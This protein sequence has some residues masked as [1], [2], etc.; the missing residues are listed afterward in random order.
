MKKFKVVALLLAFVMLFVTGCA[1]QNAS[2]QGDSNS[3]DKAESIK[4]S[5]AT[6]GPE[7]HQYT[8]A[9][10]KFKELIEEKSNGRI[11]VTLFPNAQLG[12]EREMAEGVKMGTIEMTT[13][14]SDGALPAWVR[15]TQVFSIPYLFKNREHV[16]KALDGVVSDE[17][18][19]QFEKAGFKHLGFVELGFR[20]FTNNKKEIKTAAD[21][22]GLKIRVQEAPIWFA[23]INSLKGTAT[24]I[25]FNELYT[26]LQQGIVDGQ[27]NPLATIKS[28]KFYEV[29]KYLALDAH[30]YAPG[31]V[32]MNLDFFNSLSEADQALVQETVDEMKN[33]QR[34]LI[35]SQDEEN[36]K[37]LEE[38]GMVITEPDRQ[39]F[40]D[41]TKNI[42][43][44]DKVKEL[45]RPE[46]VELVK[47]VE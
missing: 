25:P 41:A 45:V 46:L 12:G 19:P 15:D 44:L 24:P 16:Y 30:T 38:Q 9:A 6:V 4:I 5:Y 40:M 11:K 7:E 3:E 29:Q 23:L 43:T 17:L 18:N 39:S 35:A 31:S 2:S 8:I 42:P 13:V 36:V 27:E 32:L 47:N 21:V 33:Y 28:M 1:G 20:H 14:T 26:A 10:K 22:D 34:K 37:F